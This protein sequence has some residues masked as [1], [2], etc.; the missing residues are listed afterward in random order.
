[1]V[2]YHRSK[3]I[4]FLHSRFRKYGWRNRTIFQKRANWFLNISTITLDLWYLLFRY[5]MRMTL[6]NRL[7]LR[8]Q[9]LWFAT[10]R[11]SS[12][13]H[14]SN[15][16]LTF[17]PVSAPLSWATYRLPTQNLRFF[18]LIP[19]RQG[20]G[21]VWTSVCSK[22]WWSTQFSSRNILFPSCIRRCK[23]IPTCSPFSSQSPA[24][25]TISETH[26]LLRNS[27]SLFSPSIQ[28]KIFDRQVKLRFGCQKRLSEIHFVENFFGPI[29]FRRKSSRLT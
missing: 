27:L 7:L 21:A 18:R 26:T 2:R 20:L 24:P 3:M 22:T 16:Q 5:C 4:S 8:K 12:A 25:Q 9:R 14:A 29:F 11:W 28:G 6:V 1:M 15:L 19:I 10:K 13:N 23:S 17:T